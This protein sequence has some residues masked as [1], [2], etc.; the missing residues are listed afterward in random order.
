M[1][2]PVLPELLRG[3]TPCLFLEAEGLPK[4]QPAQTAV[5]GMPDF[6]PAAALTAA[7]DGDR[8]AWESIVSAYSGMVWSVARGYRLSSADAADVFQGTW[9]RL[10]EH[11]GDIRD[12]SRLGSW[13]A[14]TARREALI[15]L[16]R[17]SRDVTMDDVAVLGDAAAEG[18]AVEEDLL[19]TEEQRALWRAFAQ[20]SAACQRLLRLVFADPPARYEE[21]SAVLEM[22]VGSIGPTRSRCLASLERLLLAAAADLRALLGSHDRPTQGRTA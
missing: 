7:A 21:I 17:A 1:G 4:C 2:T 13:L 15:L 14:T 19:R 22:P 12:A 11:L 10:V 9:L 8:S 20:L 16:R 18:S 3:R 5:C 6:D